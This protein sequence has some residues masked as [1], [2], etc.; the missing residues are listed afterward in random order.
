MKHFHAFAAALLFLGACSPDGYT[1]R[2]NVEGLESPYVYLITF[3]GSH[4]VVDS[5]KVEAG[6]FVF[7]G[8]TELPEVAYLSRD[9]EQPFVRFFLENA[10]ISIGGNLYNPNEVYPT[11][12]AANE[13]MN[14]FN[15]LTF[16]TGETY[17]VTE[18][19]A[20]KQQLVE[21][22]KQQMRETIDKN[23]DNICG[24]II[25]AETG[26]MF[27]TPQ[28]VIAEID[29]FPALWQQRTELT[30]LR[31]V[32]EQRLRTEIGQPYTDIT[33]PDAD[34]K[35]ISLKSVV[36][37]PANKYVLIDFWASWCGPC[38]MEIPYLKA[39]YEKYRKKGFEIYAVSLDTEREPWMQTVK[40]KQMQ[41]IQVCD[42]AGFEGRAALDYAVESI[43]SNFLIRTS[44]AQI[45]AKQLRGKALAEKLE[46][47]LGN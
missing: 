31:N 8:K 44:D 3:N 35:E 46:E 42:L 47:L 29:R 16:N 4:N 17:G 19:E 20:D 38:M 39:D 21:R 13:A 34:G 1:I 33:A 36:E 32:M 15:E 9:K 2:G 5:A 11:G 7:T 14:A 30:E 28:E 24:M 18:S 23:R 41:W 45:V 40:E 22:Y 12:T 43:P 27:F 6:A 26:S 10:A 25:L 37:N